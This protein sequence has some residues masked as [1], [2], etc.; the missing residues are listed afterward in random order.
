MHVFVN[1]QTGFG[2]SSID[3]AIPLIFD[4]S[5]EAPARIVAVISPLV[6]VNLMKTQV[7]K[8]TSL[9]IPA[10]TLSEIGEEKEMGV[11]KGVFSIVYV[12]PEAWLNIEH[13]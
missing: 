12:S 6:L 4:V 11:K 7:E 8:L 13:S 9:G 2:K 5:L 1:F 10:D 3:Q